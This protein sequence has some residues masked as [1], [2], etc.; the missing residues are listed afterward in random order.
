MTD[1]LLEHRARLADQVRAKPHLGAILWDAMDDNVIRCNVCSRHCEIPPGAAGW[2]HQRE[3]HDGIMILPHRGTLGAMLPYVS[4][5]WSYRYGE[6]ALWIGG[7]GCT[8]ACTFCT[9][10]NLALHPDRI[11]VLAPA[12]VRDVLDTGGQWSYHRG[13]VRPA[14]VLAQVYRHQA[15][16]VLW[17]INDALIDIEFFLE[18][19]Q[20]I[21]A[22]GLFVALHNHGFSTSEVIRLVAQFTDWIYFGFKGSAN[23]EFYDKRM[24]SAG[25]VPFVL[26]NLLTW[27]R[28][29]VAVTISDIPQPPHW[30]DDAAAA[31]HAKVLYSWIAES[32]GADTPLEVRTMLRP[33]VG[34]YDEVVPLLPR[35][36]TAQDRRRARERVAMVADVARACGLRYV[37]STEPSEV[38]CAA[39][40]GLLVRF[41][42]KHKRLLESHVLAGCCEHCDAAV[43][44]TLADDDPRAYQAS[45]W[46]ERAILERAIPASR[47]GLQVH[48]GKQPEPPLAWAGNIRNHHMDKPAGGLW[49]SSVTAH[50]IV[51]WVDYCGVHNPIQLAGQSAWLLRPRPDLP[52]LR[53]ATEADV[54]WAFKEFR[55]PHHWLDVEA[56]RE[57]GYAGVNVTEA[58]IRASIAYG[59]PLSWWHCESTIWFQWAFR[60][61]AEP[62][63]SP[64]VQHDLQVEG[65]SVKDPLTIRVD[66]YWPLKL[67][68]QHCAGWVTGTQMEFHIDAVAHGPDMLACKLLAW[69]LDV[70]ISA[71]S[72]RESLTPQ[73]IAR[74]ELHI[75]QAL[76]LPTVRFYASRDGEG[77]VIET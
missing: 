9:S 57:A 19:S 44:V 23:A 76:D 17:G 45:L 70:P 62:Y 34:D 64:P 32:V 39:C 1:A 24:R 26:T 61:E 56:M 48:I 47:L 77:L 3:N 8:S 71:D 55:T 46:R 53:I 16:G 72:I 42:V 11:N 69:N 60:G 10:T 2:C 31:E 25:A 30:L 35:N 15:G 12:E 74:I 67:D 50:G 20:L 33:Q 28:L 68:P 52:V 43:P 41:D 14:D 37:F 65:L 51:R 66:P 59:E 36:A 54:L 49:S 58:A 27:H 38:H 21:K 6:R 4:D 73:D 5:T 22:A 7:Q 29:G 40:G 63:R 18:T 13:K 75:L